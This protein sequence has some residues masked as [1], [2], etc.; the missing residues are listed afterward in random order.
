MEPSMEAVGFQK[1]G[2]VD[3]LET[4]K[5]PTPSPTAGQLLVRV[6]AAGVNPADWV[7]R[8]GQLRYFIRAKFPFVPG[9][10]IAGVVENV[11]AGVTGFK[12]GDAVY[13]MLPNATMGGYA[14]YAVVEAVSAALIPPNLTFSEAAV[15]PCAALTALE[16]LRDK[17]QIKAG[18]HVLINGA[19]GGVGAFAVQIAKAMG[20]TVTA[21]CSTGS[22][23]FVKSLGADQTHDYTK[24]DITDTKTQY[25][26]IFDAVGLVAFNKWRHILQRGGKV[27]TVNPIKG[28]PLAAQM[29]RR[30]GYRLLAF[31][32][33]PSGANLEA[34]RVWI[35]SGKLRAP[36]ER[37]YPLAD[38]ADAQR[39]SEAK[40]V[41]G[42]L[43]LIVDPTLAD[44]RAGEMIAMH[45][46]G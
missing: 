44:Q 33:K 15:F 29:A 3:V 45:G 35:E 4:L 31:L 17:A 19:S 14:Q 8:S 37:A 39:A 16:A 2:T 28:N 24:S 9:L 43:V 34:L 36:I 10:D 40:H 21:V 13:A 20:A 18:D 22:L 25:S 38:A 26:I 1:Y 12:R 46:A 5:L 42:K 23:E 11:G 41:R 7:F 30:R 27:I 6:V 32:V